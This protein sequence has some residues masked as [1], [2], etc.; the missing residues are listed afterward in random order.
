MLDSSDPDAFNDCQFFICS[1]E[2]E[3]MY[4]E[5]KLPMDPTVGH[6]KYIFRRIKDAHHNKVIYK[7]DAA[8]AAFIRAHDE[9]CT[10]KVAIEDDE[11][12]QCI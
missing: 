3:F 2:V 9:L 12:C 4:S 11:D 8:Q 7:F 6:P 5:L 10:Q 1:E